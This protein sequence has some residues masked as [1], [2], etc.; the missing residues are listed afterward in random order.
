MFTQLSL[1]PVMTMVAG[2]GAVG[3]ME[4][5]PSRSFDT[6]FAVVWKQILDYHLLLGTQY[7]I[8]H[9]TPEESHHFKNQRITTT[10]FALP[11]RSK[12]LCQCFDSEDVTDV[13]SAIAVML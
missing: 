2:S 12:H 10:F 13:V 8:D 3:T 11:R 7:L 6:C 9:T 4:R 5:M 1:T